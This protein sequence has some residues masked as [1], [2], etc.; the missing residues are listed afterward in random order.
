MESPFDQRGCVLKLEG[1]EGV[2]SGPT[3]LLNTLQLIN[4][5]SGITAEK[6][7]RSVDRPHFGA[8]PGRRIKERGFIEGEIEVVGALTLGAA[9]PQSPLFQLAGMAETLVAGP[10]ALTRYN[11][12]SRQIPSASA[13]FYHAGTLKKIL[14]ARANISALMMEIDK[15]FTAKVRIEGACS[16]V[17]EATMPT[18]F[19]YDDFAVPTPYTTESGELLVNGFAVDGL[20]LSVD[21]GNALGVRSTTRRRVGRISG[22]EGQFTAKFYR[23][24]HADLNVWNLWESGA[25]FPIVGLHGIGAGVGRG[26]KLTLRAQIDNVDE[27][28]DDK[29]YVLEVKGSLIPS[30]AGNDEIQLEFGTLT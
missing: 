22:R 10:P 18:D 19:D 9:S 1:T 26:A 3:T 30:S 11:V 28:E 15:F 27:T 29:D 5:R 2:D 7:T 8:K 4:G 16:T 17:A 12:I 24:A 23:P 6:L 21:F 13:W 14:G 20:S 25:E